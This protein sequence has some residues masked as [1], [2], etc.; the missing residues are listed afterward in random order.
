MFIII[1]IICF[2]ATEK[3]LI[4]FANLAYQTDCFQMHREYFTCSSRKQSEH[5]L[6]GKALRLSFCLSHSKQFDLIL[7]D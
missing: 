5:L 4:R 1:I 3:K 7:H 6:K 2:H